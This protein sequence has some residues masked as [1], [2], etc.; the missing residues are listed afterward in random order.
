M[1][2]PVAREE[3]AGA[4]RTAVVVVSHQ[5]REHALACLAGL[6]SAGAD[7]VVLVDTGSTDGTA[8]AV[9]AAHPDVHVVA[10]DNVGFGQGANLGVARTRAPVVVVANADVRFAPGSVRDLA[11]RLLGSADVAAV[12]PQVRYPDGRPQASARR[13]PDPATAV[14]HAVFARIWPANPWT[15]RYRA[16]D[17]DP[18]RARDVDWLSGCA[19]ALR[20]EAFDAV[21]GFDP[22]YFLYVEDVDLGVRLRD[23][24]WRLRYE[25]SARVV[26]AV[27]ASTGT[28]RRWWSLTTHARSLDRFYGRHLATT[29]LR[30]LARPLVRLGLGAWVVATLALER[31]IRRRRSTTGE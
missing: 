10:V 17:L 1:S 3:S 24:G 21:H 7:E 5:T 16:T 23:A 22:G 8:E 14:G 4:P 25:P 30:R 2:G 13:L 6:A 26:H 27:G 20:R 9:R 18:A 31:L 12:G 19:L 29:P 28:R 11:E 15:R